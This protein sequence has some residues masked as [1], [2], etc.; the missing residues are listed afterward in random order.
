MGN[1]TDKDK[2]PLTAEQI[3]A[4]KQVNTDKQA[5]VTNNQTV[6]K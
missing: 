1:Q 2:K 6:K 4:A 3:Q 5:A